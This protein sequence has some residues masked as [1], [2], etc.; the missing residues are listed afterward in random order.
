MRDLVIR[1]AREHNL[2]GVDVQIPHESLT[3]I[4]GVSGS[5]KSSLAFDTIYKEGYRR[6]VESLSSYARQFLGL[7]EKPDADQID[8]LS[9]TLCIDQKTAGR[10]PRSTVGT[11]TELYD[12]LRLLFAR[13][14]TPHCPKCKVEVQ[15]LTA[16]EIAARAAID[17]DG[18]DAIVLAPIVRDRKGEYREELAGLLAGGFVRARIDGSLRRLDE[19]P[20]T[21]ARYKKHTI[22]VVMDRLRVD[23]T[24]RTRLTTAVERALSMAGGVVHLLVDETLHAYA[25][26]RA[27]PRCGLSLPELEP[28]LFSFNAPQ[29]ACPDCNGLGE[30]HVFDPARLVPDE[31]KSISDGA[32]VCLTAEGR[33]PFLR[34]GMRDIEAL[35]KKRRFSLSAPW[36]TLP[37]NVRRALLQGDEEFLA[38][39]RFRGVA[40]E[41]ERA[42]KLTQATF[43]LRHAEV[44]ACPSCV[45]TRLRPEAL[46][47]TFK[48][49]TII[50]VVR[51]TAAD[52]LR[53]F[54]SLE[55]TPREDAIGREVFKEIRTRLRFLVDV[56]LDYLALDRSA[57][58]LAGGEAQR[59]RLASQVG[60]GLRGVLYVLDEPSIGLHHRDNERLLQTLTKLRDHGNTV[61]VVEHD[62][63]TIR[64]ADHVIDIG[65]GAGRVGGEVIFEGPPA[66]L[67]GASERSLTARYLRG[68]LDIA[69]PAKR[70]PLAP[71]PRLRVRGA[72]LHN[73]RGVDVA[74]AL[75]RFIA[76]TGVSGSGKSSLVHGVLRRA[77]ADH[78]CARKPAKDAPYEALDNGAEIDKVIEIDQSPIG[79]TPRSNPATYTKVFDL[80]RDL[81]AQLPESRARGYVKG[82]FSFN[83]AGGRCEECGGAG[84]KEIEL[85]FLA[86]VEIPCDDCGGKRFNPETLEVLYRGKSITEVLAMTVDEARV[87]FAHVPKVKRIFD[88]MESVGLG[89]LPLGQPSTTLSGGEAQRVKLASELRRPDTGRT[90]Y[91]LDEPTTGL[92]IHDIQH[93]I[94]ALQRLVDHGNTVIVIEHNLDVVKVADQVID[95]GPEGGAGGGD[96]VCAGTPEDVLAARTHTGLALA[97]V[98]PGGAARATPPT[99]PLRA[100]NG[101]NKGGNGSALRVAEPQA[102]YRAG[103]SADGFRGVRVVGARK[104]NLRSIDVDIPERSITV[105]TGVSGSGKT[106]LA[107]DTLFAEGQRRY[108]ESLS[109][110]ARRFLGRLDKAPVDRIDGLAPAIAIDQKT[111]PRSPRST[112]ATVTELYDYFRLLWARVGTA[113][114]VSCKV[115][116]ESHSPSAAARALVDAHD[117]VRGH[118]CAPLYAKDRPAAYGSKRDLDARR[119]ALASEGF[120]RALVDGE[121]IPIDAPLKRKTFDRF[122]LVIDRLDLRGDL[123]KRIAEGLESAYRVGRGRAVFVRAGENGSAALRVPFSAVPACPR[124]G[125]ERPGEI[126][127]RSFSFNAHQGACPE[128]DGLGTSWTGVVCGACHGDR[129]RP[130]AL[131]VQIARTH[132]VAA[133]R[134]TVLEAQQFFASLELGASQ[135]LVA[136][137]ILREIT[138]RLAFLLDTGLD[139]LT[140]DREASTLSGGEAQRIRLASQVGLGLTGCLYVLDEPTVGLHPRDTARLLRTLTELRDL[141]N[142]VVMV[143]HDP[144][145]M[146][147]ADRIVDLG[148]GAGERGGRVVFAGTPAELRGAPPNE[149]LTSDFLSGRRAIAIPARRNEGEPGVALRGAREHNLKGVDA[150]FLRGRLTVVTGVSG[151]GKSTLVLDT[152]ERALARDLR[153]TLDGL[154]PGAHASLTRDRALRKLVSIDQ[155]PLGRSPASNPATYTGVLDPIRDLF[156]SLPEAKVRGYDKGRFSFNNPDGQ[157]AACGGRGALLVEMHFLSDVWVTCE[158]CRGKRYNAET[159]AVLYRGKSIADVLEMEIADAREHFANHR[160]VSRILG[161]L[162]DVGLGYMRLGQSGVTLSGGEAQRVKLASELCQRS[163]GDTIYLLDEPTTGLHL[164]DVEKLTTILRRLADQGN[165][166]VVIEHNLEIVKIA[167]HVID[168]GPEAGDRGGE[169]VARGTPEALALLSRTPG[170]RSYTAHYLAPV[171]TRAAAKAGPEAQRDRAVDKTM[172]K[173][174]R[175]VT[176]ARSG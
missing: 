109:T 70:R 115:A 21:L 100:G 85:Q 118:L 38:G 81:F 47:V 20:L 116:L 30:R 136:V 24:E 97:S 54:E 122:D 32:I 75:G 10:N 158:G 14:G 73:L 153:L 171:L 13:L 2:R 138:R 130:E 23:R 148:P 160:Q 89:Y 87:F 65:P 107:F 19:G 96:V 6:F 86:P 106:S 74:F 119:A 29:G 22:E 174:D 60:S 52:A 145:T 105:V 5:G 25:T 4:T 144:Q 146:E 16:Q 59:I 104:H 108:V 143:E 83:V 69:V 82:R 161:T 41:M 49:R 102:S 55:V 77:L 121:E 132:I 40:R 151:S 93:L 56:G 142:T 164:A 172:T 128:C 170:C 152:L 61:I 39:S 62:L 120:L 7:L 95:L 45:G 154:T 124:C 26:A 58:T 64:A 113:H 94:D 125:V 28:R 141:G 173:R 44:T 91:I 147:A 165:A 37:Q 92:H 135:R 111:A 139:Y 114:C 101:S 156:A 33:I 46:A 76:V 110:Y 27:C 103:S 72:R 167:D 175:S 36:R 134:M 57:A 126:H 43:L 80:I 157:C 78:S 66:G 63:D 166:V 8:G 150:E 71:S 117:G 84:V 3:V 31:S 79:R 168:L 169:V 137:D 90:L 1:G 98:M 159:L 51:S 50:D 17:A 35:A 149:S 12:Y 68:E 99:R 11:M 133:T 9:P 127:P 112:V 53:F 155:S 163:R 67:Q 34:V 15:S 129:L 18:R 176:A 131:A 123:R 162:V 88:T 48:G 42:Y 140:L